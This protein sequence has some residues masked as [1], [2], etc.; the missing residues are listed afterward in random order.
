MEMSVEDIADAVNTRR[1]YYGHTC[2]QHYIYIYIIF[3][4]RDIFLF[5]FSFFFL[6]L[7]RSRV[8]RD[9]TRVYI[10]F[11][12]VGETDKLPVQ[13]SSAPPFKLA[14]PKTLKFSYFDY[15]SVT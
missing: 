6:L 11:F 2:A 1:Y 15:T 4:C 14:S 8:S 9:D 12:V 5:F 3:C 13:T 7:S 10:P